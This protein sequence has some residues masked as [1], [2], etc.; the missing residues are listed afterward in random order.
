MDPD[1]LIYNFFASDSSKAILCSHSR[2]KM[3]NTKNWM[4]DWCQQEGRDMHFL[5]GEY[6]LYCQNIAAM[7]P[8]T[9][10]LSKREAISGFSGEQARN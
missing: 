1:S 8:E 5:V 4:V 6:I 2:R 10:K 3:I 9:S 7:L